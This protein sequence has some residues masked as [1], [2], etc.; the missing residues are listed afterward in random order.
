MFSEGLS[1][2]G[3]LDSNVVVHFWMTFLCAKHQENVVFET[4]FSILGLNLHPEVDFTEKWKFGIAS[5]ISYV[6]FRNVVVET[7]WTQSFFLKKSKMDV[8]EKKML[9]PLEYLKIWGQLNDICSFRVLLYL[10]GFKISFVD[11]FRL[12]FL[13][14]GFVMNNFFYSH[15]F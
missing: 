1:L 9:W 14:H 2:K 7:P 10:W 15:C 5:F 13:V 3:Q 11:V 12:I 8:F 4:I 6:V